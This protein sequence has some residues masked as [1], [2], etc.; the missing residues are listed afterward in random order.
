[1]R[2]TTA[3]KG[4]KGCHAGSRMP[5]AGVTVIVLAKNEAAN[6]PRCLSALGFASDVVVVDDY[7]DDETAVV[8][9]R[10]GARVCSHR[11]AN[12]ADQ[13][14]WAMDKANIRTEWVLHLDAD[15]VVTP[16]LEADILEAIDGAR[17]EQAGYYLCFKTIFQGQW[18][19][20]SSTYPVWILRLVKKGKVRYVP[21]G[22]GEGFEAD[23]ELSQ[24]ST[25]FLHYNFSKGLTEW[26]AKHNRY[27]DREAEAIL[28]S[29]DRVSI[30]ELLTSDPVRRRK[31]MKR[32]SWRLPL[33]PWIK[34]FYTYFGRL[35]ILDRRAG[36][37]YCTLQA[38]YEYMICV[39][40]RELR[41][42]RGDPNRVACEGAQQ[43][44]A[45]AKGQD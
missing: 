5:E 35:G 44:L 32:L 28:N 40:V 15:E 31:A 45:Y 37:T 9:E 14:N 24:L 39:K 33:R 42:L 8:S 30:R 22:H 29:D 3:K 4:L 26:F 25:P 10:F 43:E 2:Q 23:G 7:S 16:Q 36:L 41:H 17:P 1:M 21:R 27:S 34:F 13:R 20:F 19:R 38:F 12:F 18:L 6:L 11:F